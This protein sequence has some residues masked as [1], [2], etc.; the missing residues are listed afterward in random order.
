MSSLRIQ[1]GLLS[2]ENEQLKEDAVVL[3]QGVELKDHYQYELDK[4]NQESKRLRKER[5]ALMIKVKEYKA[6]RKK[7]MELSS[8]KTMVDEQLERV[9]ARLR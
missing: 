5:D 2:Q 9:N 4:A 6:Q 3:R 1:Q 8:Q 7:L